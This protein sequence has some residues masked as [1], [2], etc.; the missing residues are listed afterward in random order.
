MPFGNLLPLLRCSAGAGL[1]SGYR[2]SN[3]TPDKLHKSFDSIL[4]IPFLG[5]ES[6]GL[7]DEYA[8]ARHPAPR[9]SNE[10]IPNV[11]R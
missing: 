2:F 6:G 3:G 5:S 1:D 4:T 9:Q 7:Y 11:W 10:S 8:I